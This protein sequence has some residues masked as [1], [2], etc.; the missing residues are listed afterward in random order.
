MA[1]FRQALTMFNPFGVTGESAAAPAVEAEGEAAKKQA[2]VDE[3]K[4][5][6][7]ELNKRID[8]ISGKG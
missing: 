1:V 3:L 2:D 4:R 5:Q 6:M 8:K 7:D